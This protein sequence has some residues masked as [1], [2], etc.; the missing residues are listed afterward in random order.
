MSKE[1]SPEYVQISTAAAMTLKFF[2]GR[3]NRGEQLKALN[4][5]VTYEDGCRARCGYCGLSKSRAP[6]EKT[7]IR[8]DWPIVALDDIIKRTNKLAP[9][10]HRVCVSMITHPK[11]FDD[12]CTIMRAFRDNTNL[13]ISGLIAPTLLRTKEQIQTI[14]DSGA[15]MV[16]IAVDAVTPELFDKFRGKGVKGPHKWDHYWDVTKRCVE[17]FGEGK[18]GVHLIVG[19][20][21]T[22][23]QMIE[24][25]QKA[26]D[27][28]VKTHLFSFFPE[29]GSQMEEWTQP[30]YG[31][32]RRV[33]LAR[34]L[35]NEGLGS[36]G[37]MK[38][39]DDGQLVEFGRDVKDL[40]KLA[41]AFMTSGC[42][43]RDG[44]VSCNR[45]YGNERPSRPIRNY[46]FVPQPSD[47]EMIREQIFDY[48]N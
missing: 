23:K 2:P 40:S 38:F 35:I 31:Q 17:C 46:A 13:L 37:E 20:G 47:L 1:E 27:M 10:L 44:R 34:Y 32:Y 5:L 24:V 6:N 48:K 39:N 41:E 29:E 26:N 45:P 16:G 22:E 3:F 7:Y 30:P 33:Q 21:E 9:H 15:D 19:L 43:G 4:L 25:I 42:E 36:I 8:V 18:V 28:G 11:S 12:M 14:K